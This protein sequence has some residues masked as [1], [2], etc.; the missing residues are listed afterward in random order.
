MKEKEI[1]FWS[2][3]FIHDKKLGNK[4]TLFALAT[5][6]TKS[7]RQNITTLHEKRQNITTLH[8][9]RQNIKPL[10]MKSDKTQPLSIK[11][12]K[13]YSKHSPWKAT[14]HEREKRQNSLCCF[15]CME[16]TARSSFSPS[17]LQTESCKV[18]TPCFPNDSIIGIIWM[19]NYYPP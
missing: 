5:Y 2:Y 7:L 16:K 1:S 11:S 17:F 14:K 9:K 3:D 12:D 8:E 19:F 18:L 4:W 10:S 13:S 15:E 6:A